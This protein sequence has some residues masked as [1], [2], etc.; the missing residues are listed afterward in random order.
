MKHIASAKNEIVKQWKK[1]LTKK[2]RLQTNRFLI[3]GEHLIEEAVRAG[4]VKELIVRESYQ[5]P[6]SW[7]RNAD[8]FT[9]DE[10]VIKVLAETETSQGI[11][12]VCEM[13]QASVQLER[14][15]YLLLDRLQ[16]PGN[17]GT[18]IRTA[19]AMVS[20]SDRER[21][22]SITEKSSVRHKDRYFTYLLSQ[23][24]SKRQSMPCMNKGLR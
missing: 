20:S 4:I 17:V 16:D 3:E 12:A 13:K 22:T 23:C 24:H 5:V 11:F 9:I 14:G 2:G 6:G 1:L 18:M 10:A 7:K 19:D 8:V 15:R 21:L